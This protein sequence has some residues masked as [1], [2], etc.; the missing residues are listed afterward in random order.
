MLVEEYWP[1]EEPAFYSAVVRD[2]LRKAVG[3]GADML[4]AALTEGAGS[5]DAAYAAVQS[6][7]AMDTEEKYFSELFD[8]RLLEGLVQ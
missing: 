7:G 5:E 6:T 2:V 4:A 8:V 1:I 3:P